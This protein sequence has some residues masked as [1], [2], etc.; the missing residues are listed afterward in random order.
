MGEFSSFG[1]HGQISSQYYYKKKTKPKTYQNPHPKNLAAKLSIHL[2]GNY[3][4]LCT[5][6]LDSN[7][8]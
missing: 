5:E 8:S 6:N 7:K 1:K 2:H 4:S 3:R